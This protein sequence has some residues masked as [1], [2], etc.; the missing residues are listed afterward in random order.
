[1]KSLRFLLIILVL[2]VS[3]NPASASSW[4]VDTDSSSVEFSVRQMLITHVKGSFNQVIGMVEID[5]QDISL[6]RVAVSIS[7]ESLHTGKPGL[8]AFLKGPGLFYADEFSTLTFRSRKVEETA[9][10]GL[11]VLG[12]LTIRGETREIGLDVHESGPAASIGN[13][14]RKRTFSARARINRKE[15]GMTWNSLLD[16]GGW[17][18]DEEVEIHIHL[19]LVR[20]SEY[21]KLENRPLFALKQIRKSSDGGTAD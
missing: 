21:A 6:S 13:G 19:K 3:W 15:F 1:M 7:A 16:H 8:E 20:Q 5:E 17:L 10:G 14:S 11:R 2:L 12:D 18:V 4:T 9:Q